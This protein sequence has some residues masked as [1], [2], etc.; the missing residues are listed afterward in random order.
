MIEKGATWIEY[1]HKYMIQLCKDLGL[2]L[3]EQISEG[4][5]FYLDNEKSY[6]SE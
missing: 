5:N 2:T 4:D 6:T 1:R 3:R